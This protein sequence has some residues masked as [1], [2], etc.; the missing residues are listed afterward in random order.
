MARK[1][2]PSKRKK[3]K[4]DAGLGVLV[5]SLLL[6]ILIIGSI[7][8]YYVIQESEKEDR[9]KI[10]FVKIGKVH[11]HLAGKRLVQTEIDLEVKDA[12]IGPVLEARKHQV[13]ST[14]EASF[15][16]ATEA[17][18]Y[19]TEGKIAVQDSIR[20]GLNQI[21]GK[22]VVKEVLFSNFSLE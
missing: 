14:I 9:P 11:A 16:D 13:R 3:N 4:E 22:R 6:L 17:Q 20:K 5:A 2:T 21:L 1:P 18:I 19:T 8:T 15:A 7:G 12:T 10:E